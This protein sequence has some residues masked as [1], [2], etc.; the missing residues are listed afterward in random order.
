MARAV[1]L[2]HRDEAALFHSN[3]IRQELGE[4]TGE[5]R[6]LGSLLVT[7]PS[8]VQFLDA[9]WVRSL[10]PAESGAGAQDRH[11]LESRLGRGRG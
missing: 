5:L 7:Q 9:R 1:V 3:R 11:P 10:A 8:K 2:A 6:R 4:A